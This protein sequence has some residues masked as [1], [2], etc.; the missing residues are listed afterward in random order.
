MKPAAIFSLTVLITASAFAQSGRTQGTDS[1]GMDMKGME[2]K[3]GSSD[4][5][6]KSHKGVGVVKSVDGKKGAATIAHQPVQTLN[7]PAMTMTF[8]VK[9]KKVLEKIAPQKK[10]EFDFVQ[11]GSEYVITSV[12]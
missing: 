10:L 2:M 12:K 3:K 4:S 9:D 1:K 6:K 7:W 5:V 11:Q 8:V